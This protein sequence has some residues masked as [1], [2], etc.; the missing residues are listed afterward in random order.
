MYK[1]VISPSANADL[2]NTLK[3]IA[4]DLENP[5]AATNLADRFAKCYI[6]LQ[7]FPSAHELCRDPVLAHAGY[8]RYAIGNYLVIF[9]VVDDVKEVRVLHIF[10][11]LQNYLEILE[12]EI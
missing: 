2:L 9:R 8:R 11:T 7:E 3:Y 6:D 5:Q 1:V 10:H 12:G 4:Y